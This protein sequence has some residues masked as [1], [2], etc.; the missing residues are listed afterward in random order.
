MNESGLSKTS[1]NL[2]WSLLAA[3]T[4]LVIGTVGYR[5]LGGAQY[6]WMECFYMN[7]IKVTT[8]G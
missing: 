5:W 6:S 4:V 2:L 8:I 1:R 3:I 7:L